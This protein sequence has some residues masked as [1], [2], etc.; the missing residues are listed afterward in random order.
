MG[1]FFSKKPFYPF[2]RQ[3]LSSSCKIVLFLLP[4]FVYRFFLNF[5]KK[6]VFIPK[7]L[8]H[9]EAVE[10]YSLLFPEETSGS[11]SRPDILYSLEGKWAG[12]TNLLSGG[13]LEDHIENAKEDQRF[14]NAWQEIFQKEINK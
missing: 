6:G 10:V 5:L 11:P 7:V 9:D 3:N 13:S 14:K 2:F 1:N 8:N 4:T 12:W